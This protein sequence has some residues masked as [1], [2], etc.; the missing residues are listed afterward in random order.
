MEEIKNSGGIKSSVE[1][2]RE[3]AEELEKKIMNWKRADEFRIE[4][5]N[6]EWIGLQEYRIEK[7]EK[8][9]NMLLL[10]K[11][12][13]QAIDLVIEKGEQ[14]IDQF[15]EPSRF[16]PQRK[17]IFR[18]TKKAKETLEGVIRCLIEIRYITY[19]NLK[20]GNNG[21]SEEFKHFIEGKHDFFRCG[22]NG[23]NA[24]AIDSF[25]ECLK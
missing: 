20:N 25:F 14:L 1:A 10:E 17:N 21:S 19:N 8:K 3:A 23:G 15:Q 5:S 4:N 9:M 6:Q 18:D 11:L 2:F 12:I 7:T 24:N 22:E 16:Q 13:M